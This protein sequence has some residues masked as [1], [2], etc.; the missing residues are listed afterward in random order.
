MPLYEYYC[1]GCDDVFEALRPLRE[2]ALSVPCPEC[3]R[4]GQRTSFP[5]AKT[6]R[7]KR[8]RKTLGPA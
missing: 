7:G 8:E 5:T 6:R 2:A 1:E 4:D 3:N